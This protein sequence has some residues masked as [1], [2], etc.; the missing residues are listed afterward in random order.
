[1]RSLRRGVAV[2]D[3]RL[4]RPSVEHASAILAVPQSRKVVF[5]VFGIVLALGVAASIL[6]IADR[7]WSGAATGLPPIAISL[8]MIFV[9]VPGSLRQRERVARSAEETKRRYM[10]D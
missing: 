9:V 4:V 7:G 3:P 2:D 6:G 5:W 8:V 10:F 1:M